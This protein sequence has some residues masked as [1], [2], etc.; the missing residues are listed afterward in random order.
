[1]AYWG[2]A[3]ALGPNINDPMLPDREVRALEAVQKAVVLRHG[4]SE[5]ERAYIDALALRFKAP[6][7]EARAERDT[8]YAD[9]MA[10]VVRRYPNDADALTL[11]GAAVMDLMPWNYWETPTKPRARV[12]EAM[13]ALEAAIA[14]APNHA[15]AHHYYI[16]LLEASATPERAERSADQLATLT[17][18]AGHLVHMPSHI[19]ARVGRYGDAI[20]TNVRAVA[21]DEDY[22]AQCRA[23]G[24]YPLAYYPHNVHFLWYAASEAGA[25]KVALEA[26]RKTGSKAPEDQLCHF[27]M[28]RDFLVTPMLALA[29]FGKW[30]DILAL[31]RPD[32][33]FARGIWHHVRSLAFTAKGKLPGAASEIASMGP[34][35]EDPAVN[36]SMVSWGAISGSTVLQL[37]RH[38]SAGRLAARQKRYPKAIRELEAALKIEDTLPYNEPPVW[39]QPVRLVLGAVLLEAGR[40]A[41][42]ERIYRED[43]TVHRENGW[44]LFGLAQSLRAQHKGTADVEARFR[45]A[46]TRAD[47]TLT[48]SQF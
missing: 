36:K 9:A 38:V 18:S 19:Y 14:R 40:P 15:G 37:A 32:D 1:M 25:S 28:L 33:P 5:H 13:A 17:T 44:A 3:L 39:H 12:P 20:D 16:H 45:R 42:A 47:V 21:A 41:D 43:L 48:A 22:I 26:A 4:V 34:L 30:D 7:G 31:P 11:Y 8:A 6:A 27:V 2:K 29:R 46:W 35:I 23:Q 10:E 24:L